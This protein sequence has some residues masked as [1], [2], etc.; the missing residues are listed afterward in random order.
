MIDS[1]TLLT[2]TILTR[3]EELDQLVEYLSTQPLF[4]VDTESNSLFAYREQVCLVQ[5][6]TPEADILVDPLALADLSP[7]SR[8][9]ANPAQE[10]VFHAAEYDLLCLKRDFGFE[11][12]NLFDT[13]VAASVLGREALGLATLLQQ[14]FG[15][16]LDKQNQRA[17]WG[18]RP[19]PPRQLDYARLDTHYLLP[20]RQRLRD[21]LE[22]RGLLPLAQEDFQRLCAI[23]WGSHNPVDDNPAAVCWR[24]HGSTLLE[25]QQAAVL[26][27]LC[28]YRERAAHMVNRP[29]FK[30][31]GDSTL[32]SIAQEC[33]RSHEA[34][35]QV[36]GMTPFQVKRHG[37]GLLEAV[38]RGRRAEPIYPPRSTRPSDAYLRRLEALKTWRKEAAAQMGVKSDVVL[39]RNLLYALAEKNPQDR[40]CLAEALQDVP[41]RLEHFGSQILKILK[42]KHG[43]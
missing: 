2:S 37:S 21:E 19:L 26:L 15:V 38:Q 16:T 43:N 29:L 7:L 4:G 17:D 36:A 9:F 12:A 41:W 3:P 35:R 18:L 5:F 24:I 14:E 34:L 30:I 40:D 22:Q 28:R 25:P 23:E 33:P 13:M 20:L 1:H 32:L 8:L 27:E 39:P 6:S 31:I 11:F 10:K 42:V